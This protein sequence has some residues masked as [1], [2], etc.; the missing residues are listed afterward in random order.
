METAFRTTF[1]KTRVVGAMTDR[2]EEILKEADRINESVEWSSVQ[3][4]IAAKSWRRTHFTLGIIATVAAIISTALIFSNLYPMQAGL[5]AVGIAIITGLLTF[6]NPRHHAETHHG[7]GVDYQQIGAK[8]R[9]LCKIDGLDTN[10]D[11]NLSNQLKNLSKAKFELDRRAPA[12]PGGI[13]Y[14]LAKRSIGRGETGF[15]VDKI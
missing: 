11:E 3:H 13:F 7:K 4:L 10:N 14:L 12:T 9:M 6:L 1:P 2:R 8:A 15:R 5:I